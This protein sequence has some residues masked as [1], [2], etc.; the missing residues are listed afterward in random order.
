MEDQHPLEGPS[1]SNVSG[2]TSDSS[3]QLNVKTLDSQVYSF[4]VDKKMTVA[5]F[6]EKIAGQIGVPVNQQR[7]IFRGRVLKDDHLLSEYRIL[8]SVQFSVLPFFLLNNYCSLLLNVQ[9]VENGHT[10]HLVARQSAQTQPSSEMSSGDSNTN[11]GNHGNNAGFGGPGNLQPQISHSVMLGTFNVGGQPEGMVPDLSR[12]IGAVLNSIGDMGSMQFPPTH[13]SRQSFYVQPN[14]TGQTHQG[15]GNGGNVG[16]QNQAG[17]QTGSQAQPGHA[18]QSQPRVVQIPLA[19]AIPI[20]TFQSPIPDSLNTLSEFLSRMEQ[21]FSQN[22]S[23]QGIHSTTPGTA[24]RAELPPNVQALPAIEALSIVLRQAERLLGSHA[25]A[26]LSNLAGRLEGEGSSP[27][28]NIR[29]QIQTETVQSGLAMQHLGALFLELGRTLLTFRM[30]QSPGGSSIHS[31]PAVYISSSGPNPIMAQPFPLQTHPLF[32]GMGVQ[33][34]SVPV[35]PIGVGNAPRHVNIHIHA[36]TALAPGL[37]T[38]APRAGN[39]EGTQGQPGHASGPSGAAQVRV[40]PVRSVAAGVP[41]HSTGVAESGTAPSATTIEP[42]PDLASMSSMVARINTRLRDLM[43]NFPGQDQAVPGS[44]GPAP[45][46]DGAGQQEAAVAVDRAAES[47]GSLPG[48]LSEGENQKNQDENVQVSR[49]DEK[50]N[51]ITSK[52]APSCS[53]TS[54][55]GESSQK[56]EGNSENITSAGSRHDLPEAKGAPLGLGLGNLERK[57]RTKQQKV[58]GATDDC[59]TA[60]A[61]VDQNAGFMGMTP[62]QL[63]QT[64]GSRNSAP[65]VVSD[66][67]PSGQMPPMAMSREG[68]EDDDSDGQIDAASAVSQALRG[69]GLD[70]L[71]AGVSQ[72]TGL[73]SPNVLRN[74]LQE[75]TQ[76]PQIMNTVSQIAQ[77]VD[78]QDIGNMFSGGGRGQGGG[79]FDLSRMVQQ[80]MPVV[81]QVLGQGSAEP[82]AFPV[83]EPVPQRSSAGDQE[84]TD[85]NIQANL[86]DVAQRIEHG[87]A[88]EDIFQAMAESAATL[89]GSGV[90]AQDLSNMEDLANEY[91]TMLHGNLQRRFGDDLNRD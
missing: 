37:S 67:M 68:I 34:N 38:M 18:F 14:V 15:T 87:D 11:S 70:N 45:G 36:G 4:Q 60:G 20:P 30:G 52:D 63:L 26:A 78:T 31:G 76:N 17:N 7:L 84:P 66:D 75:L 58:T 50:D 13:N 51:L 91:M 72:Q 23:Q 55:S 3:V 8:V 80:M 2:E 44:E 12:V 43:E 49:N 62:Q 9:E 47:V 5:A 54:S 90:T 29:S 65:R 71:L 82:R 6:K 41:P 53:V 83:P 57:K 88:P 74:M 28:P 27:D 69:P 59:R 16:G 81:S 39:G 56:K 19:A 46:S 32:G 86:L 85:Q 73:G 79:G 64:L 10:L 25:V 33:P 21:V 40:L 61:H 48:L 42:Q 22:V 1:T 77:Q 24:P 35:S 89:S